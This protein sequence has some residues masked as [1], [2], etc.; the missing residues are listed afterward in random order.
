MEDYVLSKK[1]TRN[2]L[3]NFLYSI[4]CYVLLLVGNGGIIDVIYHRATHI[5]YVDLHFVQLQRRCD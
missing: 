5:I 4:S 1:G 2:D 3:N